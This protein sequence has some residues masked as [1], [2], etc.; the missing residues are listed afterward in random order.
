MIQNIDIKNIHINDTVIAVNIG[1]TS[2]ELN[3]KYYIKEIDYFH[4]IEQYYFKLYHMGDEGFL[5]SRFD[6]DL[7]DIRKNKLEKINKC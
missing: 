7:N 5:I 6:I 1:N 2:L 4:S 3:K